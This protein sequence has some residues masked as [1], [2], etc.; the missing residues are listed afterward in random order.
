MGVRKPARGTS[1]TA[2]TRERLPP[3]RHGLNRTFRLKHVHKDGSVDE[4]HIYIETGC[5]PDGRLGEVF[6]TA[7]RTGSLARGTLDTAATMISMMLQYGVPLEVIANKM[8]HTGFPP[9]GFTGDPEFP[10]CSSVFDLIAQFL[11]A[12][13]GKKEP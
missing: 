8:R 5:Y 6:I 3:E 7:D 12:R 9:S 13:Y 1:V 4:M 10:S 11:L 2:P